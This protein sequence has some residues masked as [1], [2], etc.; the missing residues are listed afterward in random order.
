MYW[1]GKA[2]N[3]EWN[4]IGNWSDV[5]G[6]LGGFCVPTRYDD[7]IFDNLS[8]VP[9]A[10][11][12]ITN[13]PANFHNLTITNN[14][15][16]FTFTSTTIMNCYGSL[17]MRSNIVVSLDVYFLSKSLTEKITGVPNLT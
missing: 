2:G 4:D 16:S 12:K 11:V 1:V 14:A 5:S 10:G 3:G 13:I 8:V 6:G 9:A 15:P 7:V 17:N